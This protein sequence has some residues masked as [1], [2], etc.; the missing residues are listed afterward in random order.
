MIIEEEAEEIGGNVFIGVEKLKKKH[1]E[2]L[3]RFEKMIENKAYRGLHSCHFDWWAA[4]IHLRSSYGF[5]FTVTPSIVKELQSD[6]VFMQK[7]RRT[8]Y[9]VAFAWGW[10]LINSKPVLTSDYDFWNVRLYK[11]GLSSIIFGEVKLLKSWK[12]FV[13]HIEKTLYRKVIHKGKGMIELWDEE[14][15]KWKTRKDDLPD[16]QNK[17]RKNWF[18]KFDSLPLPETLE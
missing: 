15:K 17:F 13:K 8:A 14:V 6:S 16:Q 2:Q 3:E 1:Y 11:F 7:Y 12:L 4:P 10:D 5:A 18:S 9:L